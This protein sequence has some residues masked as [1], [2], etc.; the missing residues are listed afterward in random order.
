M[1]GVLDAVSHKHLWQIICSAS[2]SNHTN[3]QKPQQVL[4]IQEAGAALRAGEWCR[5]ETAALG[6]GDA[7]RFPYAVVEIKV[8]GA[9]QPLWV[10]NLVASGE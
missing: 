8:E 3:T 5:P 1:A 2:M 10:G 4:E 6:R 7:E 9:G